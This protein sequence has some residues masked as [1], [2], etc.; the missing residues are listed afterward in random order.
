[1]VPAAP[2]LAVVAA[3]PPA[4]AATRTLPFDEANAGAVG[5]AIG[6][7]SQTMFRLALANLG[8]V[9]ARSALASIG[10][11][12]GVAATSL[13]LAIQLAFDGALVGTAL[14][15]FVSIQVRTVDFISVIVITLMAA[16]CVADVLFLNM[17]ERAPELA[18]LRAV[19]WRE[20]DLRHL[21]ELEGAVLGVVGSVAGAV[22]GVGLA[23]LVGGPPLVLLT[24]AAI[25]AAAGTG[26]VVLASVIPAFHV[27]RLAPTTTLVEE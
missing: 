23:L 6:R 20:A 9:R 24:A 1:M 2:G 21:V 19:G 7:A 8:R 3:L 18:A 12:V 10:V 27:A 11:L 15:A 26:V 5:R 4:W 25:A 13:L 14:G 16:L 17:R 22:L